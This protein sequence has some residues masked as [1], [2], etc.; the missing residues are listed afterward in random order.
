M[1]SPN[2]VLAF[3]FRRCRLSLGTNR[4]KVKLQASATGMNSPE[5]DQH[6]RLSAQLSADQ[7]AAVAA[8]VA[9]AASG[10]APS[11]G[12]SH[13]R[14]TRAGTYEEG[15]RSRS[16]SFTLPLRGWGGGK[17]GGG[18]AHG[19][20]RRQRVVSHDSDTHRSGRADTNGYRASRVDT[21][22]EEESYRAIGT[23]GTRELS[24]GDTSAGGGG[25]QTPDDEEELEER[26]V[27]N[28]SFFGGFGRW[29]SGG[30]SRNAS[31]AQLALGRPAAAAGGS[32]DSL[33]EGGGKGGDGGTGGGMRRRH[34]SSATYSV[35]GTAVGRSDS[36]RSRNNRF[37]SF[38]GERPSV[39]PPST[40]PSTGP[41]PGASSAELTG[42]DTFD[43]VP[44]PQKPGKLRAARGGA[45]AR[46]GGGGALQR[47]HSL[48]DAPV[49]PEVA[50]PPQPARL[51]GGKKKGWGR[52]KAARRPSAA[53]AADE[54]DEDPELEQ[55]E[56]PR[57]RAQ[58]TS[59]GVAA[60]ASET[61]R[62]FYRST[63]D[64]KPTPGKNWWGRGRT[65]SSALAAKFDDEDLAPRRRAA[66][67]AVAGRGGSGASLGVTPESRSKSSSAAAASSSGAREA[68]ADGGGGSGSGGKSKNKVF[69]RTKGVW[70]AL[71]VSS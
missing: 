30:R 1:P 20:E 46:S 24:S 70:G 69:A 21:D 36:V 38:T 7:D 32:N 68:A 39:A 43:P 49:S 40:T 15:S 14:N 67:T 58:S 2:V 59:E 10:T 12:R 63:P 19:G 64:S 25:G 5:W 13:S 17:G 62:A 27:R 34:S 66:S 16:R 3:L 54:V 57:R 45:G 71:Q 42:A 60:P 29:G 23:G 22:I 61:P 47:S 55:A 52:G 28:K 53:A 56:P 8:A 50:E 4:L 18:G 9:V 33:P 11:R 65:V 31:S 44:P 51:F 41:S 6:D 26:P 37:S 48:P 35:R